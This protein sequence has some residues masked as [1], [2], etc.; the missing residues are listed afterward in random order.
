MSL[1]FT[2]SGNIRSEGLNSAN[3]RKTVSLL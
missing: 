2:M 1:L 3:G